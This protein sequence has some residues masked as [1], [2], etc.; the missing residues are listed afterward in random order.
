MRNESQTAIRPDTSPALE[1][2]V[3]QPFPPPQ[4]QVW[5]RSNSGGLITAPAV[6]QNAGLIGSGTTALELQLPNWRPE[7]E[8]VQL[9]AESVETH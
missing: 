4:A 9:P 7:A 8:L 1:W 5:S 2:R 3:S 6:P